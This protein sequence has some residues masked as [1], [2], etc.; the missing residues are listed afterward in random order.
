MFFAGMLLTKAVFY[1]DQKNKE[2]KFYIMMSASILQML[3][4]VHSTH[5]A[6]LEYALAEL[7]NL[8]TSEEINVPEYLEK[9]GNK[10]EVFME[11]YTL[12]LIKAVPQKGR[13][14]ISFSSWPEA[15]SLIKQLRSFTQN[16]KDKS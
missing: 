15:N 5:K 6:V 10:I 13:K 1:F 12:L 8:E 11:L 3:D 9:E 4:S 7:K 2:K 14:Y 16:A